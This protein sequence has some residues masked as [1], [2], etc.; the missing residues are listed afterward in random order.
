MDL[1]N[2][3]NIKILIVE[4]E[5]LIA[6]S[7]SQ[8]LKKLGYDILGVSPSGDLAINLVAQQKPHLILMDIVIQGRLDGIQAAKEIFKTYNIPVIF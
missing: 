7:L 2:L 8:K 6:Q 1:S 5:L 4:D 3:K